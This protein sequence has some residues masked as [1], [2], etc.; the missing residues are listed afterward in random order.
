M[1]RGGTQLAGGDT[2]ALTR[3]SLVFA[4]TVAGSGAGRWPPRPV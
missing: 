3:A 1:G 4:L 2:H